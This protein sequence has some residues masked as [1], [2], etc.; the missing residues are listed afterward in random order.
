MQISFAQNILFFC[1][2]YVIFCHDIAYYREKIMEYNQPQENMSD[3]FAQLNNVLEQEPTFE[4][5]EK[6]G[7]LYQKILDN[8]SKVDYA[9]LGKI[10]SAFA[11]KVKSFA[12]ANKMYKLPKE[13]QQIDQRLKA[14]QENNAHRNTYL[15]EE[16]NFF[17]TNSAT[18]QKELEASHKQKDSLLVLKQ[19]SAK[20]REVFDKYLEPM[21]GANRFYDLIQNLSENQLSS[22]EIKKLVSSEKMTVSHAPKNFERNINSYIQEMEEICKN[23]SP[24][25]RTAII[26]FSEQKDYDKSIDNI[27]YGIDKDIAGLKTELDSSRRFAETKGMM[28]SQS[29]EKTQKWNTAV[30]PMLYA[31]ND[32]GRQTKLA[33]LAAADVDKIDQEERSPDLTQRIAKLRSQTEPEYDPKKRQ[34]SGVV[35]N[36]LIAQEIIKKQKGLNR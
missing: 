34:K 5:M 18:K 15:K 1:L 13:F 3:V 32:L 26:L 11:Q 2:K 17:Q 29:Q 10:S 36:D 24:K 33:S 27:L 8:P 31:L 30:N 9:S 19:N 21:H 12:H 20:G 6:A 28:L 35:K 23:Q 14:T 16:V 25:D 22:D 7:K 4:N